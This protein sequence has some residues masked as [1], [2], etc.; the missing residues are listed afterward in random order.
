MADSTTKQILTGIVVTVVGGLMVWWLTDVLSRPA[1][2][3]PVSPVQSKSSGVHDEPARTPSSVTT[4]QSDAQA[5]QPQR[6]GD[7]DGRPPSPTEFKSEFRFSNS[8]FNLSGSPQFNYG[9]SSLESDKKV[10][11]QGIRIQNVRVDMTVHTHRGYPCC[12]VWVLFGPGP[13]GF[14]NGGVVGGQNPFFISPSTAVAPAQVHFVVGNNGVAYTPE[15]EAALYATYRFDSGQPGG[16]IDRVVAAFGP[17]LDL[18]NGLYAQIFL[19]NGNPNV[20]LDLEN[21]TLTVEGIKP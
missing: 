1:K 8:R 13:F 9:F 3:I 16:N 12:D 19:W 15:S 2:G 21:I 18:P 7:R 4:N 20:D 10:T 6:V 11:G 5:Q 17:Q 14:Q